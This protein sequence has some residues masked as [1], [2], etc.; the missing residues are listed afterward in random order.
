[1]SSVV[2][3]NTSQIS[4]EKPK[5]ILVP[6]DYSECSVLACRYAVQIACILGAEIKLVHTYYSPAFDLIELS[7]AVQTQTQLKEEVMV[8]KKCK[9]YTT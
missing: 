8:D 7:G 1:M 6:V 9:K 5:K 2:D 3:D 4:P